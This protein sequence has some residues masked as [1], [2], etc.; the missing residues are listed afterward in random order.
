M[1]ASLIKSR[2]FICFIVSYFELSFLSFNVSI[3]QY[4]RIYSFVYMCINTRSSVRA[5]TQR[6]ATH[7]NSF[8]FIYF[9]KFVL[10]LCLVSAKCFYGCF[11]TLTCICFC[12]YMSYP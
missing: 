6:G 2:L 5:H 10:S 4:L 1:L 11:D 3:F 9:L 7:I 12:V 8:L